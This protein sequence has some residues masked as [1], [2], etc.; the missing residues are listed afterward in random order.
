MP[1]TNIKVKLVGTDGNVFVVMGT[2]TKALKKAGHG[3]LVEGFIKEATSGDYNH[4][5][6]TVMNYV[7][8]D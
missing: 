1:K 2:V 3:K 8:V 4:L 6:A 5:M 7:E